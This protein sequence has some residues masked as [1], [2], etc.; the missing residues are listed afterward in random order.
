MPVLG[1]S[2][3][4]G[5]D[6]PLEYSCWRITWREDPSGLQSMRWQNVPTTGQLTL[7]V[8]CASWK[9]ACFWCWSA[10]GTT[11]WVWAA[12]AR[13]STSHYVPCQQPQHWWRC[14][15]G[16]PHA[17]G[18]V[19][20][21]RCRWALCLTLKGQGHG[22]IECW[23]S[24]RREWQPTPLFLLGEFHGQRSLVTVHGVTES[25]MTVQLTLSSKS[26]PY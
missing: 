24:L 16:E 8:S 22:V 14:V 5:N 21:L 3:G 10:P 25:D 11:L 26:R 15:S 7:S 9:Q 4:E 13:Q 23:L 17:P 2:P 18:R 20:D 6:N 19:P 12:R 1:R